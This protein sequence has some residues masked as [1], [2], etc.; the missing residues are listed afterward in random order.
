MTSKTETA[1]PA[2]LTAI[3][4]VS[5]REAGILYGV[6][7]MAIYAW[8]K[9]TPTKTPL[10]VLANKDGTRGVQISVAQ[11]RVWNKRNK[12]D[13]TVQPE[14][15][16]MALVKASRIKADKKAAKKPVKAKSVKKPVV[17]K[18]A[19]TAIKAKRVKKAVKPGV[20]RARTEA[21]MAT[22]AKVQGISR[23]AKLPKSAPPA[24][25]GIESVSAS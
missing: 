21:A 10:P 3:K 22:L 13:F 12:M 4:Q 16:V 6:S 20:K 24:P 15:L 5:L 14:D 19:A 7:H 23:P 25:A 9:G 17:F 2:P 1:T 11:L 18:K 8:R